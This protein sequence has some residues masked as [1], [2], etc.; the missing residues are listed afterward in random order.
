MTYDDNW[1]IV[2]SDIASVFQGAGYGAGLHQ[3]V[4]NEKLKGKPLLLSLICGGCAGGFLAAADRLAVNHLS[5]KP[6]TPDIPCPRCGGTDNHEY[7][8]LA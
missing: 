3:A 4:Q 7:K 2:V 8:G 6:V 5:Q 1:H